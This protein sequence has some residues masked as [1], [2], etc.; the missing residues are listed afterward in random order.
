MRRASSEKDAPARKF[1]DMVLHP[2]LGSEDVAPLGYED[3]IEMR[4]VSGS[5]KARR[6]GLVDRAQ[7][8]FRNRGKVSRASLCWYSPWIVSWRSCR[9]ICA[10][11]SGVSQASPTPFLGQ[12]QPIDERLAL[13]LVDYW[14]IRS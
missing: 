12:Q 9:S 5:A 13:I 3:Q 7:A 11:S 4:A 6:P 14:P 10:S 2:A 1:S 8:L